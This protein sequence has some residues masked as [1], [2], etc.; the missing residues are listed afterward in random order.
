[1]YTSNWNWQNTPTFLHFAKNTAAV[2]LPVVK[3]AAPHLQVTLRT[4]YLKL[5][6]VCVFFWEKK[7]TKKCWKRK[8]SYFDIFLNLTDFTPSCVVVYSHMCV[9]KGTVKLYK[10][11]IAWFYVTWK[12]LPVSMLVKVARK[13]CFFLSKWEPSLLYLSVI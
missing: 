1:M 10:T 11:I 9:F 13:S 4:L 6:Q 7:T 2:F 8:T 12:R 3:M 5:I